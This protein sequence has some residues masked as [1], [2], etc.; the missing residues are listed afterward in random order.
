MSIPQPSVINLKAE[1]TGNVTTQ[2]MVQVRN[3]G[4][5]FGSAGIEGGGRIVLKTATSVKVLVVDANGVV[6]HSDASAV[7]SNTDIAPIPQGV[8]GPLKVTT[9]SISNA[10]HT[11]IVYW[12]VKK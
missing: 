7:T 3:H 1:I 12:S 6:L 4:R 11:L 9:T 10:A 8:Q 5:A 2:E